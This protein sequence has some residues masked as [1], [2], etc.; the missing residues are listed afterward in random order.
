MEARVRCPLGDVHSAHTLLEHTQ[1]ESHPQ[2]TINTQN[3]PNLLNIHRYE[4]KTTRWHHFV[5]RIMEVDLPLGWK[6]LHLECYDGTR[7]LD[8]HLDVFLTQENL[9]TN[10]DTIM[11]WVFPISLKGA[12]LTWYKGLSSRSIDSFDTLVEHFS[13]QYTT[14]RSHR[15][16]S[17]ALASLWQINDESL[18]KFMDRFGRIIVQIRNLNPEV[19]LQSM[20]L[21]LR[22]GIFTDSLF[23][24]PPNC[25]N[26]LRE[27]AKSYIQMEEMFKFKKEVRQAEQKPDKK[28]GGTETN[29]HKL[30]K[31]HKPDKRQSHPRG[32][33]YE[34]YTP[35]TANRTIILEEAFNAKIPIKL[36]SPLPPKSG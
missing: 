2:K 9:Y 6:P 23:K 13:S 20:L 27:R 12:T 30:N 28:E 16:T 36:P 15:M 8:K 11:C 4:G 3:D 7:D 18:W 21:A 17:V 34:R 14:S 5:D 29:S 26:K 1:G 24:K 33:R 25:M 32:P 10:D 22:L 35:L 31:R 19:A